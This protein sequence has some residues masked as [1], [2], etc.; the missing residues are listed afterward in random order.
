MSQRDRHARQPKTTSGGSVHSPR[1]SMTTGPTT[2]L[3]GPDALPQRLQV[4]PGGSPPSVAPVSFP[5]HIPPLPPLRAT[6]PTCSAGPARVSPSSC[7]SDNLSCF[8][9]PLWAAIGR[10]SRSVTANALG[11]APPPYL[12]L[13]SSLSCLLVCSRLHAHSMMALGRTANVLGAS[14]SI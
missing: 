1:A 3:R 13:P 12:S 11:D 8:D 2:E 4:A 9:L 14:V 10:T 7:V 6:F 5:L